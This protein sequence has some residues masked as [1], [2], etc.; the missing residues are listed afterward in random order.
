MSRKNNFVLKLLSISLVWLLFLPSLYAS[1]EQE[2]LYEEMKKLLHHESLSV[3]V[4]LQT[5]ADF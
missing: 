1:D 3:R 5:V 2:P 4:L